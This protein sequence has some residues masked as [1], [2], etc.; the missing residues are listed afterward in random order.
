MIGQQ[1]RLSAESRGPTRASR[2][3]GWYP[4]HPKQQALGAQ[5]PNPREIWGLEQ[6]M[7]WECGPGA[8]CPC[9]HPQAPGGPSM[10]TPT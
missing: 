9:S 5:G 2:K 6:V 8:T 10:Q 7:G 4:E 1:V 3:K